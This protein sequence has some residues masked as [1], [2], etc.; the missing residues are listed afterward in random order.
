MLVNPPPLVR[1]W[2]DETMLVKG[3]KRLLQDSP[4][5]FAYLGIAM[6][7]GT[8]RL[9]RK[10]GTLFL[11]HTYQLLII[12]VGPW[13]EWWITRWISWIWLKGPKG[14]RCWCLGVWSQSKCEVPG[15]MV[16]VT[17]DVVSPRWP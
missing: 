5:Q 4:S 17:C 7:S 9:P 11:F 15:G 3:P 1:G 13:A 8:D 2:V 16:E 6:K 12:C 10:D 14:G